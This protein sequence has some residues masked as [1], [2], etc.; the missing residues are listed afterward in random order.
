MS[1][2]NVIGT[3]IRGKDREMDL[4]GLLGCCIRTILR[5]LRETDVGDRLHCWHCNEA[6]IVRANGVW[7][8]LR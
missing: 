2:Q 5:D 3:A 8:W 1:G 7:A 4:N 6:M